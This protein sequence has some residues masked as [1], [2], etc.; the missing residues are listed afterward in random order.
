MDGRAYEPLAEIEVDQVKPERQ[1]FM[2]TGQGPDNAEYQLDLRF[3]MPLDPRTRTVLGELL[4][5]SD[6]IIS[7]RAPGGLAQALRQRRNRAPQ[8]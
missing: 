1:G 3:G 5:H 7:R 8:R 2:L 4:S 6:L